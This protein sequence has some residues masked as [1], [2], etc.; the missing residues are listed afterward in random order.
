[1]IGHETLIRL[2]KALPSGHQYVKE[3]LDEWMEQ[4]KVNDKDAPSIRYI[5]VGID[6]SVMK[7]RI[8]FLTKEEVLSELMESGEALYS[9]LGATDELKDKLA[10]LINSIENDTFTKVVR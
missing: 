3:I 9:D 6:H 1:M 7:Y 5:I 8:G 10:E 2:A 4:T